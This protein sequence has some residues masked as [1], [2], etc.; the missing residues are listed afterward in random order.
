MSLKKIKVNE[1]AIGDRVES[2]D[3][4]WT[5]TEIYDRNDN[6]I[7]FKALEQDEEDCDTISLYGWNDDENT[8]GD[9]TYAVVAD[10]N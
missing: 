4:W 2:W 5:I 7:H 8:I 6:V 10:K 3:K 9:L 1:I